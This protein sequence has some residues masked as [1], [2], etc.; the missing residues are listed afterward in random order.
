MAQRLVHQ[1]IL[2]ICAVLFISLGIYQCT[3][4]IVKVLN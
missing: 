1:S 4:A 2:T 3:E